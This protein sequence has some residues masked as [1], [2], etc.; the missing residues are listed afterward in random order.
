MRASPRRVVLNEWLLH[1]LAGDNGRVAQRS[2][3]ELLIGLVQ[4][5][6]QLCIMHETAWT[7]KAFSLM[8]HTNEPVRSLSK[9]L[10]NRL[11]LDSSKVLWA[12]IRP[13]GDE[14]SSIV[15]Q[16]PEEDRYLVET[17]LLADANL[18]VTDDS[19]IVEAYRGHPR[20]NVA[21]KLDLILEV[22]RAGPS[23]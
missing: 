2:S 14:E 4:G 3:A 18:L 16:C 11:L 13:L 1:D 10:Q 20:V 19:G 6:F 21:G 9:L 8:R 5:P 12:S 7:A 17:Y 15:R 22:G 23:T